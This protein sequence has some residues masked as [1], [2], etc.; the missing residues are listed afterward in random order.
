MSNNFIME[1]DLNTITIYKHKCTGCMAC[2]NICPVGAIEMM[3]DKEGF[4]YPYINEKI[5]TNC[6]LCRKK[7][8]TLNKK[9]TKEFTE[10]LETPIIYG[11]YIKD[12]EIREQSSSGGVF[13]ALS[14][15]ILDKGGYVCAAKLKKGGIC[16]HVIVDNWEDIAFLRSA[17]YIQ[18]NV[19]NCYSNIKNLLENDKYVLFCGTPCQVAGL[20]SV[21]GKDYEKL[22]TIDLLCHGV[23][24]Q[25]LFSQYLNEITNG[26][27]DEITSI[28]FKSKKSG[29][30]TPTLIFGGTNYYKEINN[31]YEKD[32]YMLGF[33]KN[34]TIRKSCTD[35]RF[36]RLPRKGDI[37]IGDFWGVEH[38]DNTLDDNKGCSI[39]LCNSNKAN[40]II[41]KIEDDFQKFNKVNIPNLLHYNMVSKKSYN[42]PYR[43][44]FFKKYAN[45]DYSTI[46][47]LIKETLKKN[48]GIAI[49]NFAY[50]KCNYGSV[51]TGYALQQLIKKRGYTPVNI[52]FYD[53][54]DCPDLNNLDDFK[55][56]YIDFTHPCITYNQMKELNN[57]FRTFIVGSDTVFWDFE[58][59]QEYFNNVKFQFVN[60]SK[61][62]CSYAASFGKAKL[63]KWRSGENVKYTASEFVDAKRLLKRFSHV[64]V[65]ETSGVDI[66]KENFDLTAECVLDPVFFLSQNEWKSLFT[67]SP[68]KIKHDTKYILYLQQ[69]N[70]DVLD[71]ID[72][73]DNIDI[74]YNGDDYQKTLSDV[75]NA[76]LNGPKIEDWLQSIAECDVLYT[77][78]YHGMCFAILFN[79][80]FILFDTSGD[81]F[82]RCKSLMKLLGI[83][84]R[85]ATT[86]ED[87]ERLKNKPIDYAKVNEKLQ[88]LLQQSESFLEKILYLQNVLH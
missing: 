1:K 87:I 26:H 65:R 78:S 29:W 41:N 24:S 7:C 34:L 82:E 22:L 88:G 30:R 55:K 2:Y 44:Y 62:I 80:Q 3:E 5:C 61:N 83:E 73:I 49:Y 71:Y 64:S 28:N 13:S 11:G 12:E 42:H 66:C 85:L 18:S 43:G 8:P 53:N 15:Y 56:H 70:K 4:V 38:Y 10:R 60:F 75:A 37:T 31:A 16:E 69:I 25:K 51:L 14:K 86:I 79:K 45:G 48:D 33:L 58:V 17:K 32:T 74:L 47:D 50:S 52:I 59:G 54:E 81:L 20:Y 21:L 23:P 35:C 6:G 9:Q 19:N 27:S 84:S 67:K 72:K 57:L 76:K 77:D 63:E 39:I 46:T 40:I 36:N 68:S